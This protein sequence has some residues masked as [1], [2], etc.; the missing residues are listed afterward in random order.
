MGSTIPK[1]T[2]PRTRSGTRLFAQPL[3]AGQ[4]SG[5]P[6][7]DVS[8]WQTLTLTDWQ[9]A[10][11]NGARFAYV[12]ATESTDYTSSQFSEQ[13][14]DSY[15]AGLMHGA[16]HFATPN[17]SSGAAQANY[18]VSNGGGW[19]P[20]GH[21]LPPLLDIEYNPYGATCYGMSQA[22]MVAWIQ[23]FS[24]TVLARTGRLPAIYSTT[25]WWTQCTGNSSAFSGNPLFI[26]RYTTSGSP[27][28]LPGSWSN[29]AFWQWADSGVFPGDQDVF[30]GNLTQ[31]AGIASSQSTTRTSPIIAGDFNHDGKTDLL[32]TK[33]DGT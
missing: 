28:T 23:D 3:V 20:D 5:T 27:G 15:A 9:T 25:D 8:G 16:Y 30:N 14:S 13:Y 18:F 32:A 6:G 29:Y 17:T 19:S 7:L 4:P 1:A 10:F 21:T 26:A 11:A 31:L 12:K 22:A 33:P 24:N 2:I